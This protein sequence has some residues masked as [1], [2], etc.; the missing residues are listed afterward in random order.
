MKANLIALCVASAFGCVSMGATLGLNWENSPSAYLSLQPGDTARIEVWI[1]LLAGESLAG[2]GFANSELEGDPIRQ[3][4]FEI[5]PP[6]WTAASS[7]IY[8]PLN[9]PLG[10]PWQG[11]AGYVSGYDAVTMSLYGPGTFTLAYQTIELSAAAAVVDIPITFKQVEPPGGS[12]HLFPALIDVN[13]YDLPWDA[14][15]NTTY[16]GYAAFGGYGNGG[17]Q[18]PNGSGQPIAN[19]LILRS[20]PE[21]ASLLLMTLGGLGAV[22]VRRRA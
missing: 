14:R 19:P 18:K 12:W 7:D 15:Y 22:M 20:L 8:G 5:V 10:R 17:W 9:E 11:V 4:G 2:F 1:N 6:N 21:P 16:S 3:V 13:G